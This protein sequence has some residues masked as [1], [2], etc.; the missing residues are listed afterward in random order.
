MNPIKSHFDWTPQQRNGILF[1]IA[2]L[3]ASLVF[4]HFYWLPKNSHPSFAF[5]KEDKDALQQELDSLA[6]LERRKTSTIYPFNPNYL[7]D[8]KAYQLGISVAEYDRLKQFRGE[9]KWINSAEDFQRV[10]KVSDSLLQSI[11]PYFKFPDWVMH[12]QASASLTKKTPLSVLSYAE[13]QDLNTATIEDLQR[14]HGIG[15][16]L[17]QRIVT[18]RSKY[19]GFKDDLQLKDVYGLSSEVMQQITQQFT[20]KATAPYEK[21]DINQA[22]V[23]QLAE[24]PYFNYELAREIVAFIKLREGISDFKELAKIYDFPMHKIDRIKLYLKINE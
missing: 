13:K 8:A 20:V 9:N 18:L 15:E 7:T 19:G 23:V 3:L 22:T 5:S 12:R 10:T 24:I 16:V 17:A 1:L 2:I 4:Q 11:Q 14:I 6:T 21:I